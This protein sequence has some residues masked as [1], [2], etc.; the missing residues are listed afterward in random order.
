LEWI[1]PDSWQIWEL[2]NTAYK[3]GAVPVLIAPRI[4]G[5]CFQ[6]FKALGAF[7]RA[8][9]YFFMKE[10]APSL[11]DSWLKG[12]E[13]DFMQRLKFSPCKNESI[14]SDNFPE[15]F[16][17]LSFLLGKTIPDNVDDFSEQLNKK[18]KKIVLL[19]NKDFKFLL[20]KS[21]DVDV[22]QRHDRI[23]KMLS[24]KIGRTNDIKKMIQRNEGFLNKRL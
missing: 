14:N 5:S 1:Y 12:K 13:R 2:Y 8:T 19:L 7:A 23:N 15:R 21:P 3:V 4:H 24:L 22:K 17:A 6:L 10:D 11:I 20:S 9:Y 18:S 16:S